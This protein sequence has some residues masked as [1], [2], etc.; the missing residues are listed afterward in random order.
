MSGKVWDELLGQPEAELGVEIVG[1]LY[2]GRETI[3]VVDALDA[4]ALIAGIALQHPLA[5]IHLEIEFERH[6][7]DVGDGAEPRRQ[8]RL[9]VELGRD[10]SVRAKLGEEHAN[11]IQTVRSVGYR[12]GQTRWPG[13]AS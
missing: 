11:L 6:A 7:G 10:A 9:E 3:D 13:A 8:R 2:V 12:F 4:R 5:L 1:L